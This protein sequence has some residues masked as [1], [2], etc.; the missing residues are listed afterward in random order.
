[1]VAETR[2]G[3]GLVSCC[4]G[5]SVVLDSP[6]TKRH[7]TSREVRCVYVVLLYVPW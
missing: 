5:I 3:L 2:L 4:L 1:V 6:R 7:T